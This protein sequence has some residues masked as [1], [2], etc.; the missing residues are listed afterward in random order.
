MSYTYM[1]GLSSL[2]LQSWMLIAAV[3][4]VSDLY[5]LALNEDEALGVVG[6]HRPSGDRVVVNSVS[7]EF[8][9]SSDD[10]MQ[11]LTMLA[12]GTDGVLQWDPTRF[13]ED[14][15]YATDLQDVFL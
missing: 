3:P 15:Y 12:S 5:G 10:A 7:V 8:A 6:P 4:A 9:G 2:A 1:P 14:T 13:S 11:Y